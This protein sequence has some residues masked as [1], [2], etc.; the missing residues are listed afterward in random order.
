MNMSI[1]NSNRNSDHDEMIN[2]KFVSLETG[3]NPASL[4]KGYSPA[5]LEKGPHERGVG[6]C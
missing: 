5:K 1:G 4:G 2:N 3:G 6:I